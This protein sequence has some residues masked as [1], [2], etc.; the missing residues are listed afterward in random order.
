MLI[1]VLFLFFLGHVSLYDTMGIENK[2]GQTILATNSTALK[3]TETFN[4]AFE[5]I[6]DRSENVLVR[7]L[8]AKEGNDFSEVV[9]SQISYDSGTTWQP[10]FKLKTDKEGQVVPINLN[11]KIS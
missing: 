11:S 8:Y 3:G 2:G 4:E 1:Q 7:P 9:Y 6:P 10:P 5:L